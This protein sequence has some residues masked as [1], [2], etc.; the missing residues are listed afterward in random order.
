MPDRPVV[1]CRVDGGIESCHMPAVNPEGGEPI[2]SDGSETRS[3]YVPLVDKNGVAIEKMASV[4]E[5]VAVGLEPV[6][7]SPEFGHASSSR[8]IHTLRVVASTATLYT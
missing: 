8:P 6:S 7:G 3:T 5:S 2:M 1:V 4:P